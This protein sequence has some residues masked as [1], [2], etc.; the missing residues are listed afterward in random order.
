MRSERRT[1]TEGH[2]DVCSLDEMGSTNAMADDGAE[3]TSADTA[4]PLAAATARAR[5]ESGTADVGRAESGGSRFLID[6]PDDRPSEAI[7]T[8]VDQRL[9]TC[10]GPGDPRVHAIPIR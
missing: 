3:L 10:S 1:P 7:P 5:S 6:G 8:L 9:F 4:E 2:H